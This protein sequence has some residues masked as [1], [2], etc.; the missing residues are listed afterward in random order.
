[1][2]RNVLFIVTSW[3]GRLCF[4]PV[5]DR[6]AS[7]HPEEESCPMQGERINHRTQIH[8]ICM[9]PS[10]DAFYKDLHV[11]NQIICRRSRGAR[12]A[13]LMFCI[14]ILSRFTHPSPIVTVERSLCGKLLN[15]SKLW[16]TSSS[17]R[18]IVG[19]ASD[20]TQIRRQMLHSK[21]TC[22]KAPPPISL[23]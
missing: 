19:I 15:S 2:L 20:L 8:A 18:L 1:M 10:A 14:D 7:R 23:V 22:Q 13:L 11:A 6:D 17:P 16:L 5:R 3:N 4:A 21:L 9:P 12:S